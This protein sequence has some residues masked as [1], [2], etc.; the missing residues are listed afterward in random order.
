[1]ETIVTIEPIGAVHGRD[2][3][4]NLWQRQE[5]KLFRVASLNNCDRQRVF[6]R[7]LHV[8]EDSY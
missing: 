2:G 3:L 5:E 4:G 6:G 8:R 7:L 1:M